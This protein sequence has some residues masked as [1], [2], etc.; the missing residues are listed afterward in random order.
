MIDPKTVAL[1]AFLVLQ[2]LMMIS[3]WRTRRRHRAAL[4]YAVMGVLLQKMA[5]GTSCATQDLLDTVRRQGL[6]LD[7]D[8][9]F[10]IL[11]DL[12][13]LGWVRSEILP[14]RGA[15]LK[16]VHMVTSKGWASISS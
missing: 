12:E 14:V 2:G 4:R 13:K 8:E 9:L 11:E 3:I 16:H 1:G 10:E 6:V 5:S 7:T 15:P